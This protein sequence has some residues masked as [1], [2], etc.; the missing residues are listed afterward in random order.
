MQQRDGFTLV[1]VM[2]ALGVMTIGGMSIIAMQQQTTRAN[3]HARD[4]TIATTIA[5]T[6]LER[7]K[8][9]TLAWNQV[10]TIPATD[11]A[12]TVL[13]KSIVNSTPGSFMSIVPRNETNGAS[14]RTISNAFSYYGTDMDL[15]GAPAATLAQVRF[16]AS[17]RLSWIYSNF[18]AMRADVRVWWTKEAPTHSI[19]ADFPSCAED[20]SSLNPTGAHYD[21]YHVVYLS[22]VLRPTAN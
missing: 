10:T 2:I 14:T 12:Q 4:M 1:E 9:E 22:T 17:Y 20:N 21:D 8:L 5:Q 3:V 15:S 11:L 13:L 18:R 16:C 7:L 19:T 6:Q